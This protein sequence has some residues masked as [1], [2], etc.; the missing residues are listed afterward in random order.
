MVL[1]IFWLRAPRMGSD[2]HQLGE[3]SGRCQGNPINIAKIPHKGS[4]SRLRRPIAALPA[5]FNQ[6]D[7]ILHKKIAGMKK[8]TLEYNTHKGHREHSRI[9][10]KTRF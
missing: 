3:H 5:G 4:L 8:S 10:A 7:D 6:G 1:N 2:R 9:K